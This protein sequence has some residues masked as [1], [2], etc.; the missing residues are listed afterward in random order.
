MLSNN[1][2]S[3]CLLV[4][5]YYLL[6]ARSLYLILDLVKELKEDVR[7]VMSINLLLVLSLENYVDG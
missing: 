1:F 5:A 4:L 3:Y 2:L 7:L 6:D